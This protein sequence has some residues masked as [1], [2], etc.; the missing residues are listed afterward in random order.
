MSLKI[1]RR[2]LTHRGVATAANLSMVVAI[3]LLVAYPFVVR[4]ALGAAYPWLAIVVAT[5]LLVL[6]ACAVLPTPWRIRG[7]L[8]I[9]VIAI[10][11]IISGQSAALPYLPPILLNLGLATW[12]G[13]TLRAG[14]EPMISHFAR[15]ERGTLE[16]D[17]ARYTRFLTWLWTI[18][19]V[20]MAAI[21]AGLA[22]LPTAA[23]WQWFS[24]LGNWLC[25]AALFIGEWMIR[26][27]LFA[28]YRHAS[29]L[30]LLLLIRD[31]W[32]A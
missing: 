24:V 26:H 23:A 20:A 15:L 13:T 9:G 19:F 31:R 7:C 10:A 18:F 30:R 28:Q 1:A 22:M 16:P 8:G 14:R 29:P 17:L 2:D 12:F 5:A 21:S 6:L 25:V 32:R 4:G 27:L 3:L 11:A